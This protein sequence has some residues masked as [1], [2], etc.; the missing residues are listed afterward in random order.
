MSY[1]VIA[2]K[3][4]PQNFQNMIGQKHIS[5]TLQNALKAGRLPQAMLFTGPRGTGKTST[6]RILAKS[7][8][9]QNLK[10]FAPCGVCEDCT[11]IALGRSLDVIEI[12]GA[13]NNGVDSIRELRDSVSFRPASGQ[14][15][16]Y[17]IDEVHMLSISAF[18]ALLKTL[19][20]PPEHV[21]FVMA[22]TEVHKIPKTILSRC[23][24][25][26][27]RKI[28]IQEMADHLESICQSEGVAYEKEALWSLA[29]QG[30]GSVRD[31]LSYL[32]Q[33]I[34][35]SEKNITYDNVRESLGLTDRRLLTQIIENIIDADKTAV[36]QSLNHI[37][38]SGTDINVI[39]EDLLEE[40]K[41]LLVVKTSKA[42]QEF[43]D[44]P[45]V[46]IEILSKLAAKVSEPHIH[47][48]FDM[49]LKLTQDLFRTQ[50]QKTVLEVGALKLCLYPQIIDLEKQETHASATSV[51]YHQEA[52][53]K[54]KVKTKH[55]ALAPQEKKPKPLKAVAANT[56][57]PALAKQA[58]ATAN[59]IQMPEASPEQKKWNEFVSKIKRLNI[60][61]GA[62]LQNC[63][64][65]FLE[66]EIQI[67]A[68]EKLTFVKADLAKEDFQKMANNYVRTFL[69]PEIQLNIIEDL[70]S[71]MN[72]PD[73][74]LSTLAKEQEELK[75]KQN[76][77]VMVQIENSE[78]F[79][80]LKKAFKNIEIISVKEKEL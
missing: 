34:T 30:Q 17:I 50:D 79:K 11:D 69:G 23:H 68:P 3:W 19:E 20:E 42:S 76:E 10:D 60:K 62:I 12:D 58:E 54:I 57:T 39:A 49:M 36:M 6:A 67:S 53:L 18:N 61:V 22:T 43:L 71:L 27:F 28:S 32:D 78:V 29:R 45:E 59:K 55:I 70:S 38:T 80:G 25:F 66:Q 44:L 13:S 41:N 21:V 47:L 65:R 8:R 75:R 40:F 37:F 9:C 31:S 5:Q 56:Q 16:V 64:Y 15:K 63:H 33:V 7:L 24:R 74:K 51:K 48:L 73:Q 72:K 35:Y 2:L 52:A 77:A 14:K 26:D 1:Q 46:E 4:R